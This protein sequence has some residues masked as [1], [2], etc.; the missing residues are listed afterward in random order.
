[1]NSDEIRQAS[2]E[3]LANHRAQ[4][5]LEPI[6]E[7]A[8][9]QLTPEL[10]AF[11]RDLGTEQPEFIPVVD[12]PLGLYGWCVNGVQ[13]KVAESGGRPVFGWCVWEWPGV[14]WNAE[15]HCV[16]QGPDGVVVDITPKPQ[17]E[18]AIL[19]VPD[20]SRPSDFDFDNRPLNVRKRIDGLS[21]LEL[22]AQRAEQ[23]SASQRTYEETRAAK[24]GMSLLNW[25]TSKIP[26][27]PIIPLVDEVIIACRIHEEAMDQ[28]QR[29]GGEVV[30]DEALMRSYMRRIL[31]IQALKAKM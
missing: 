4:G 11:C 20:R 30:M 7:T 25:L 18:P 15:F 16:W 8:P 9:E 21:P 27:N 2:A 17:G 6:L 10:L 19:F 1:M 26:A 23:M 12:E 14:M 31:A 28:R 29:G 22:A 13:L 5:R 3:M 24:K